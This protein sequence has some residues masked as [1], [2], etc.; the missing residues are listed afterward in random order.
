MREILRKAELLSKLFLEIDLECRTSGTTPTYTVNNFTN[1]LIKQAVIKI[2]EYKIEEYLSQWKQ[3]RYELNNPQKS[4]YNFHSSE[5]AGGCQTEFNFIFDTNRTY[6]D[7]EDYI[8]GHAPIVLGRTS[9][10]EYI[11][12]AVT[13]NQLRQNF[14][15]GY[16]N[17]VNN[18]YTANPAI[19]RK[20]LQ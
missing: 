1:S 3:I 5:T 14:R 16:Y 6:I 15:I 20:K 10:N 17:T 8:E 12:P 9:L 18:A 4:S 19:L 13:S 7:H 2:G 11:P